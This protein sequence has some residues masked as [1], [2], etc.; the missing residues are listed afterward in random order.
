LDAKTVPE[1]DGVCDLTDPTAYE[2]WL[3]RIHVGELWG[4]G[5]A[6]LP[7]QVG[8]PVQ[9]RT[10]A[11]MSR[12]SATRSRRTKAVRSRKLSSIE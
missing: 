6:S 2:H 12:A 7:T 4:V 5:R 9:A 1:L 3:C 8:I 10:V 11:R